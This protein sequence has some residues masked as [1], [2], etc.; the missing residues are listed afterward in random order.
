MNRIDP[1]KKMEIIK[2]CAKTYLI[3]GEKSYQNRELLRK[4]YNGEILPSNRQL[5]EWRVHGYFNEIIKNND[6]DDLGINNDLGVW[7]SSFISGV[8]DSGILHQNKRHCFYLYKNAPTEFIEDLKDLKL[9][10]KMS[11]MYDNG[12]YN[13]TFC[14]FLQYSLKNEPISR[15][16]YIAGLFTGS[17]II[18][19]GEDQWSFFRVIFSPPETSLIRISTVLD[20]YQIIYKI[21]NNNIIVSPFYGALFFGYMPIHSA[22]R[23]IGV[24]RAEMGSELALVYWHM[25]REIGEPVAPPRAGILP[26]ASGYAT[27]WNREILKKTDIRKKGIEMGILGISDE[28]RE[29]MKEWIRNNKGNLE[30]IKK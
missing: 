15:T 12:C 10:I 28:L 4:Y 8:L 24:K 25:L 3:Y 6:L 30:M 13:L 11:K 17:N 9:P 20:K 23:I 21:E 22:S 18:S 5:R 2:A 19:V 26:Y 1:Q 29:L 14:P 7:T 16:E 27:Y